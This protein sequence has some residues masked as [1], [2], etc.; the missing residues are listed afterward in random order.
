MF[1]AITLS[2]MVLRWV[3]KQPWARKANLYGVRDDELVTSVP[4]A[5]TREA[6]ARV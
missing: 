1:T 2:R 3:V 4:R 6:S 5:R